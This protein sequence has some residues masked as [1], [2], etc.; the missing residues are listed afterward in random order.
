MTTKEKTTP[1]QF[2]REHWIGVLLASST[3]AGAAVLLLIRYFR[4]KH[5]EE[6]E[7]Q[8]SDRP[9]PDMSPLTARELAVL[10]L[11]ATTG[12]DPTVVTLEAGVAAKNI[13]PNAAQIIAELAQG[14]DPEGK[15]ALNTLRGVK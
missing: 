7:S 1:Q 3:L 11:E 9:S 4:L 10:E 6:V 13:I 8:T 14:V 12:Q 15:E 2:A 5:A